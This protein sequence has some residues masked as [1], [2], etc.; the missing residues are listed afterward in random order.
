MPSIGREMA[1]SGDWITPRLWGE[2]WFEKPA[3][4]YWMIGARIRLGLGEEL[5]RGFRSRLLSVLFL[6]FFSWSMRREFGERVGRGMQRRC[7]ATSRGLG[8][9]QLRG[10]AGSADDRLLLGGDAAGHDWRSERAPSG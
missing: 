6:V 7:W 5:R 3:L 2:P 4:L 9:V 8:S 1:R 10:G